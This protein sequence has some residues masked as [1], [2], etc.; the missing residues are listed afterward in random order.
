MIKVGVTGGIGSGKTTFCKEWE[1]QG[2]Y[3]VY[4]DDLA[5]ELM[6]SDQELIRD[7]KSTF[8]GSSYHSDGS[9][10]RVFL[11]QEA[12]EK[13]RVE[14]LN[15]LVHPV[16]WRKVGELE[17]QQELDGTDVFVR[18]AAILLNKGRPKDLDFVVVLKAGEQDRIKWVVERD[19]SNV[20][21]VSDRISA[22]QPTK[23]LIKYADFVITNNGSME[24]LQMKA[25]ELFLHIKKL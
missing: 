9:L 3:V 14:E 15:K 23:E 17:F 11:A 20:Q 5:K 19:R 4:A 8:G 12:F 22:Q 21:K 18:E 16:L 13:G 2:A 7:I 10:N 24:E 6:V 1:K 25:K